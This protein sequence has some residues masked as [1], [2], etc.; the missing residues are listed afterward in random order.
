MRPSQIAKID[1]A[2]QQ[3]RGAAAQVLGQTYSQYRLTT[4]TNNS[5]LSG[6]PINSGFLARLERTTKKIE[7]ENQFFELVVFKATCDNRTLQLGDVL[8]ETGYEA[9]PTTYVFAQARPTR[10][11]LWIRTEFNVFISRPY[12]EAARMDQM[13]TSGG[14]VLNGW[15]GTYKSNEQILTLTNGMYAF[16]STGTEASI[17][18]Q[19]QPLNR[20]RDPKDPKI[21]T[22]FYR[23]HFLAYVPDVPGEQLKELDIINC[24]QSDRYEIA[25]IYN[26][27]DV[28]LTGSV[29]IVEK[30]G[31]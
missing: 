4:T 21:P 12:S 25:V 2:I 18:C 26:P 30:L 28:G 1:S 20:I 31:V 19:L 6:P 3:G 14:V 8:Q 15:A 23:E 10:E 7:V 13:P 24:G 29:C 16:K 9:Q 17:P 27:G 22:A 5:I 11:T